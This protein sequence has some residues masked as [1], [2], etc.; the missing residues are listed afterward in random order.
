LRLGEL[1]DGEAARISA[2][3]AFP[4]HPFA[5]IGAKVIAT[6]G[7]RAGALTLVQECRRTGLRRT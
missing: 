7:D 4:E 2:S 5:V 6:K 1:R 3:D